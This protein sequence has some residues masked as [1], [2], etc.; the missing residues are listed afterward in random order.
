MFLHLLKI[1]KQYTSSNSLFV[2]FYTLNVDKAKILRF[3][4]ALENCII[5][6]KFALCQSE[7][8]WKLSKN[9]TF[10]FD[11]ICY[12]NRNY[13]YLNK[14][15]LNGCCFCQIPKNHGKILKTK[16]LV[17][18]FFQHEKNRT[19]NLTKKTCFML[20]IF[21]FVATEVKLRELRLTNII[22]SLQ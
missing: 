9:F 12:Y 6:Q 2:F 15:N 17:R 3:K 22:R 14:L 20:F 1:R 8:H 7:F 21:F 16:N 4:T 10:F 11:Y 13:I 5:V 19:W 18:I